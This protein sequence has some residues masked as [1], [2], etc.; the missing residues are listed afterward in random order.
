[1]EPFEVPVPPAVFDPDEND[2]FEEFLRLAAT[3]RDLAVDDHSFSPEAAEAMAV[4]FHSGLVARYF[5]TQ[6]DPGQ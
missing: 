4:H 2:C 3:H 1:M 5:T 6:A